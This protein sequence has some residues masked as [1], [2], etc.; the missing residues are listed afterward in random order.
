MTARSILFLTKWLPKS[1]IGRTSLVLVTIIIVSQVFTNVLIRHF[2]VE[3]QT[4]QRMALI[5][6]ELRLIRQTLHEMPLDQHKAFLE[7]VARQQN[8]LLLPVGSPVPF[9]KYNPNNQT[10]LLKQF[11]PYAPKTP[12]DVPHLVDDEHGVPALWVRL[13]VKGGGYW[14]GVPTAELIGK[15]PWMWLV[16]VGIGVVIAIIWAL[17]LFHKI[18][19]PLERLTQAALL[20]S[21]GKIPEKLTEEGSAEIS[22]LSQAFNNMVSEIQTLT[23]NRKFLLA[24]VSHDLR[25]P[26][27]RMRL[28]IE[29]LPSSTELIKNDL[30]QDIE[31]MN[32][33]IEQFLTFIRHGNDEK[34]ELTDINELIKTIANRYKHEPYQIK[35]KLKKVPKVAVKPMAIQRALINLINNAFTHGKSHV[36][37]TTAQP[38][39]KFQI[40]IEDKGKGMSQEQIHSAWQPFTNGGIGLAITKRIIDSMNGQV[41]L[42]TKQ[43]GGLMVQITVPSLRA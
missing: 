13:P 4:E 12:G 25:T 37:I 24:G 38:N 21:Q 8:F 28:A 15:F 22:Q 18:N 17:W 23:E 43:D 7:E 10:P 11:S 34:S 42:T 6:K 26:L 40:T 5:G 9:R 36:T 33:I 27:A 19:K 29:M 30:I 1:L 3:P 14:I 39:D 20:M 41:S 16:W 31:D 2:Y 35:L 32:T